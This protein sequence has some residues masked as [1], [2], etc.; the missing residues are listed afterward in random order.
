MVVEEWC[1]LTTLSK[2][3]LG[4]GMVGR[5]VARTSS[6]SGPGLRP[7]LPRATNDLDAQGHGRARWYQAAP[8]RRRLALSPLALPVPSLCVASPPAPPTL[9]TERSAGA[10]LIRDTNSLRPTRYR[11]V[12][13]RPLCLC[14]MYSCL[15]MAQICQVLKS[16]KE[17]WLL[18]GIFMFYYS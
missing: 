17:T 18:S 6:A 16:L 14:S 2:R 13:R 3:W 11:P 1:L 15:V 7:W 10:Q 5:L 9:C 4:A 12:S 8:G